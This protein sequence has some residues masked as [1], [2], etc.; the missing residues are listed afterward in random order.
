MRPERSGRPSGI[1]LI[2]THQ[3]QQWWVASDRRMASAQFALGGIC[4]P[5]TLEP[6]PER[7]ELLDARNIEAAR[8]ILLKHHKLPQQWPLWQHSNQLR[9]LVAQA[10]VDWMCVRTHH[11]LGEQL[12]PRGVAWWAE[13]YQTRASNRTLERAKVVLR[14]ASRALVDVIWHGHLGFAPALNFLE[15]CPDRRVQKELIE[16]QESLKAFADAL[17]Q[18]RLPLEGLLPTRLDYA[19]RQVLSFE[20]A[21]DAMVHQSVQAAL[22]QWRAEHPHQTRAETPPLSQRARCKPGRRPST[23]AKDGPRAPRQ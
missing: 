16:E 23:G 10:W 17:V 3:E 18:G 5:D 13:V 7:C 6:D 12:P 2:F 22:D 8:E 1:T 19:I 20:D 14:Q 21:T 4:K 9:L 15:L 11:P